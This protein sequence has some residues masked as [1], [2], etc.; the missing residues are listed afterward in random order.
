MGNGRPAPASH[1]Q[2]QAP[3]PI[4]VALQEWGAGQAPADGRVWHAIYSRLRQLV[5]AT[6]RRE[7]SGSEA[8]TTALAHETILRLGPESGI[9]W[10]SREHFYRVAARTVRRVLVDQAR[11]HKALKRGAGRPPLLLPQD[12]LAPAADADG[13]LD[14]DHALRRLTGHDARCARVVELRFFGGLS[15][16]EVAQ[17]LGVSKRTVEDDWRYA[18]TWLKR[19]LGRG[20]GAG[21][22][23][24]HAGTSHERAPR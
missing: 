15:D 1:S 11:W 19:E 12:Q 4:T 5:S 22:D 18:R 9:R 13:M 23:R 2:P 21:P 8:H 16:A 17:V 7:R 24:G 14:L 10:R 6:S 3:L 20:L